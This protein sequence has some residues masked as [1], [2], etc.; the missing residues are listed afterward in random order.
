VRDPSQRFSTAAAKEMVGMSKILPQDGSVQQTARYSRAGRIL[1]RTAISGVILILSLRAADYLSYA[2][3]AITYP[4]EFDYGE[5]IVWQQ[6]L[7]IPG[8][9]MYREITHFPFIPFEYPPVYHLVVRAIATLG[10]DLLVAGRAI[11][12]AATITIAILA[13]GITS[14]AMRETTSTRARIVGAATAGLMIFTYNPVQEWAVAMRVDMLAISFSFTGV[15]LAIVAG[16]RT[17]I[18]C[19]AIFMFVLAV[20]T[21]QTQ[22]S[23]PIAAMLVSLV[24]N[25]VSALKALAFG[26]F[27][28][29]AAFIVLELNTGGGFWHHIFEYN[30][31]NRFSFQRAVDFVLGQQR[32]AVGV[33]VGVMAFV[34]L[35][36]TEETAIPVQNPKGLVDSIR[37]S[38]QQRAL[39]IL[40]L[41]F[42]LAS[43]QLV[44]VGKLGSST[45]YFIEWMCITT[46]PTGMVAS[47]AWDSAAVM[48][49]KTR[50]L[51]VA[52]GF[53]LSLTIPGHALHRSLSAHPIVYDPNA[54]SRRIYLVNLIRENPKPSL[55]EDMVLLLRAGQTVPIE[56]GIFKELTLTGIWNQRPFLNLIQNHAF[57][58]IILKDQD[59]GMFTSEVK[60]AIENS[61]P[62]I[63]HFEN[64][65]I[66]RPPNP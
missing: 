59:W 43:A 35:C 3:R 53:L 29:G 24:V 9:Q 50:R 4:F 40:L 19:A 1:V 31:N 25:R 33:L 27:I 34:F 36:W 23:A 16:E 58:L 66:R 56:P 18:L 49:D 30:L 62:L 7:L 26:L 12:L 15:Y 28:G 42:V 61:Y 47:L 11:T 51:A 60:S 13:G 2:A 10:I 48:R 57:G 8:S 38:R 54:I 37:R 45:N 17:N 14:T 55:S 32:D 52:A 64:Y 5:G 63:E 65:V 46:V 21:K 44:S 39:V 20:Y 6:A 41:W 22:L